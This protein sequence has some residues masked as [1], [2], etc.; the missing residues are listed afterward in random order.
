MFVVELTNCV[1]SELPLLCMQQVEWSIFKSENDFN[2]QK[3]FI[4]FY[5]FHLTSRIWVS[6][7]LFFCPK[8]F[9]NLS[10]FVSVVMLWYFVNGSLRETENKRHNLSFILRA[11]SLAYLMRLLYKSEYSGNVLFSKN[12]ILYLIFSI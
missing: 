10:S 7:H 4:V 6:E 1:F 3:N 11:V 9:K 8:L 12:K 2:L 5:N